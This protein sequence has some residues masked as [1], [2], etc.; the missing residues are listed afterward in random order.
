VTGGLARWAVASGELIEEQWAAE[1]AA[2]GKLTE[3]FAAPA[4]V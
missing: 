2:G 1:L 3:V 4:A